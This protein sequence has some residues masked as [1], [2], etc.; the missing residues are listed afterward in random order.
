MT[1]LE[2][3]EK[4]IDKHSGN[5]VR[6]FTRDAPEEVLDN[7]LTKMLYYSK[8]VVA[9]RKFDVLVRC[10]KCRYHFCVD[11]DDIC[12]RPGLNGEMAVIPDGFCAWGESRNGSI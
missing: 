9:I 11:G 4:Q 12:R 5:Y 6:E 1:A 8:A 10:E 7:I 2:Y 3:M